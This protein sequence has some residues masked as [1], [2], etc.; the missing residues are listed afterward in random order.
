MKHS[1][2][3]VAIL[4]ESPQGIPLVRDPMKPPPLYWKLPG[5]K[6]EQGES[7]LQAAVRELSEEIGIHLAKQNLRL[8]HQEQ[9]EDHMFILFQAKL[10]SLPSL[11]IRGEGDE[12]IKVFTSKQIANMPDFFPPHKKVL[13]NQHLLF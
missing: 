2:Y 1:Q 7:A 10:S 12:E 13:S 5:G 9:R 3:A 11:K 6:S 4:V 8:A